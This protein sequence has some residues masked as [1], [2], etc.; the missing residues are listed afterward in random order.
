MP[1]SNQTQKPGLSG[2]HNHP[3]CPV[4]V[5]YHNDF[6]SGELECWG[7]TGGLIGMMTCCNR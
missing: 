3:V 1:F 5:I 7:M 2:N 6:A 4:A